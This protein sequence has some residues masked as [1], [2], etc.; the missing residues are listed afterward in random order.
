METRFSSKVDGWLIPVMILSLAGLVS[1]LIAVMITE[2]PWP[3]R[4]LV[5]GVTAVVTILL[6]SI[7]R[8][9]YYTITESNLRVVSGPFKW[10]IP[11]AE[12]NDITPSRNPLSSPALSIDRL[13]ISYG[14]K[15]SIL[16]SPSDKGAFIRSIEQARS[17]CNDSGTQ[18]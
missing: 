13:K 8:S 3:V 9:T 15:K 18:A 12:I 1:A 5:A 2:S 4:G 14:K 17:L 6:F 10:T 16:V 7:F 11:L